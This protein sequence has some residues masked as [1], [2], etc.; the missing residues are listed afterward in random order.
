MNMQNGELRKK[1]SNLEIDIDKTKK[2]SVTITFHIDQILEELFKVNEGYK[3]YNKSLTQLSQANRNEISYM[4]KV[5]SQVKELR[6]LLQA[7]E[8]ERDQFKGLCQL[9]RKKLNAL[10]MTHEK[11]SMYLERGLTQMNEV[12]QNNTDLSLKVMKQLERNSKNM[13]AKQ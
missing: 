3:L 10:K 11:D 8:S 2:K 13:I 6:K 5:K 7:E 9:Q 4:D 1:I 12:I